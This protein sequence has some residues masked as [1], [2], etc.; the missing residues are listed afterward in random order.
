MST[1]Y[2]YCICNNKR[3]LALLPSPSQNSSHLEG[4]YLFANALWFCLGGRARSFQY[5]LNDDD[6][7]RLVECFIITIYIHYV[8]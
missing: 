1:M 3:Y 2:V 4:Q 6:N 5:Q 7:E 8:I